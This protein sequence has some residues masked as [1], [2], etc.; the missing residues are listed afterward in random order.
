MW[1]SLEASSME[2]KKDE[3]SQAEQ[4]NRRNISAAPRH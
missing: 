2:S 1:D 3:V 4:S